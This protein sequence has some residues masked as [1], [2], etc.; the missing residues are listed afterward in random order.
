MKEMKQNKGDN[1]DDLTKMNK[2][3]TLEYADDCLM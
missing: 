3:Q 1:A 2:N